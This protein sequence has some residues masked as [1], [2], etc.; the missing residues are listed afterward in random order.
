MSEE[1]W[2]APDP[3]ILGMLLY[4]RATDDV[5]ERG[6]PTFGDTLLVLMNGGAHTRY[7][8]LP[9]METPGRW[10]LL[11]NTARPDASGSPTQGLRLAAHSLVALRFVESP[12]DL[13]A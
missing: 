2:A 10:R 13:A 8:N 9:E 5:D 3:H 12:A 6:R 4:G 11:L 1:D 7:V